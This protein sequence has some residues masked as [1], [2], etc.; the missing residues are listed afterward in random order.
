MVMQLQCYIGDQANELGTLFNWTE[1]DNWHTRRVVVAQLN[2][3]VF[4]SHQLGNRVSGKEDVPEDKCSCT[5]LALVLKLYRAWKTGAD[6]W[7]DKR[8]GLIAAVVHLSFWSSPPGLP[9]PPQL[10]PGWTDL[11]TNGLSIHQQQHE[12]NMSSSAA[13]KS[14]FVPKAESLSVFQIAGFLF[15]G[16]AKIQIPLHCVSIARLFFPSQSYKI[17][18]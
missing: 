3:Q 7:T 12:A 2:M 10:N 8:K 9:V 15:P 5:S 14:L 13:T 17:L 4:V 1:Q 6:Q 18:T 16:T 11:V